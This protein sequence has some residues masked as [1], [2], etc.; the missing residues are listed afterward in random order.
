MSSPKF[1]RGKLNP[2]D[3]GGLKSED[4]P[5][6]GKVTVYRIQ[7]DEGR[8]PFR[9]GTSHRW[10]DHDRTTDTHPGF[11]EEFGSDCLNARKIGQRCGCAFRSMEQLRAWFR[12]GERRRMRALG[13][14]IV[15]ME[16]D[17]IL[18]ESHRQLVFARDKPL[19]VDVEVL[20]P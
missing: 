5:T 19:A 18:A 15:R 17:A 14:R 11:L 13:Y 8:G 7:D 6:E 16:V 12:R 2:E 3:E 4:D 20:D 9:P 1:P 10:M